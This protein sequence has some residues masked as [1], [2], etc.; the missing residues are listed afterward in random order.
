VTVT[1]PTFD[2]MA[3]LFFESQ[4]NTIKSFMSDARKFDM[5]NIGMFLAV[6]FSFT[7]ITSGT[8][9][10][11]GIFLPCI[12]IGCALGTVYAELHNS[13]FH[14]SDDESHEDGTGRIR[15]SF[16]AILGATAM[17]SGATRMTFALAVIMLETTASVDLFIPIVLTLFVSYGFGY[18]SIKK[19]VYTSAMRTKNI[20]LL[21]RSPPKKNRNM[22]AFNLMNANAI[23]FNF[24]TR[25]KEVYRMLENTDHS[26]FPVMNNME[27]P[28]GLIERDALVAMIQNKCWY[29]RES[30][31]SGDFGAK[32][33]EELIG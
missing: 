9:V 25:V 10:P 20:P 15:P 14:P 8:I 26:A 23:T 12:L 22:T 2:R 30:R 28:V 24:I 6:W 31:L 32:Q 19:S 29:F 1:A 16:F 21:Q 33:K 5:Y 18:I 17:L 3:T 7:C 11:A 27:R 13:I 4:I